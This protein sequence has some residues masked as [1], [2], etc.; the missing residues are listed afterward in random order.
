M[1]NLHYNM[2][3]IRYDTIIAIGFPPGGSGPYT[4]IQKGKDSNIQGYS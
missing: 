4:C 2:L 1:Y 3:N